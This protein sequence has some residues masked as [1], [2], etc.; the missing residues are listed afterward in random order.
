MPPEVI[1]GLTTIA[2]ASG[3]SA[4]ECLPCP[5]GRQSGYGHVH[6]T[7]QP[8]LVSGLE[9]Q[10]CTVRG[11]VGAA[12]GFLSGQRTLHYCRMAEARLQEAGRGSGGSGSELG[13]D[14]GFSHSYVTLDKLLLQA[15]TQFSHL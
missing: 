13:A 15:E 12:L 7:H 8:L 6:Q 2:R 5:V 9:S 4:G 1:S 14:T 10:A 11:G 3:K